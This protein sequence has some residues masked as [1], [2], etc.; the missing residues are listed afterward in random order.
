MFIINIEGYALFSLYCFFS[1]VY[2]LP[3]PCFLMYLASGVHS[4][5]FLPVSIFFTYVQNSFKYFLHFGLVS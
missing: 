4:C 5:I 2:F 3:F 1:D